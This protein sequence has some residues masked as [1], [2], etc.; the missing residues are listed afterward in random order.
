MKGRNGLDFHPELAKADAL[1]VIV[2]G[3]YADFPMPVRV[4]KAGAVDF[5]TK[6]V[7]HKDLL[8]AIRRAIR[9]ASQA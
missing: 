3:G 6:P 8:N 7:H 9:I 2:V 1:P 5:L 4:M